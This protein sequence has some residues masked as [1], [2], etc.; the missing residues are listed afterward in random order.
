MNIL[1]YINCVNCDNSFE[2][3]NHKHSRNQISV[4]QRPGDLPPIFGSTSTID[5]SIV[6][7]NTNLSNNLPDVDAEQDYNDLFLC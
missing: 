2:K 7:E 5:N 6:T 4:N 1:R 3:Y